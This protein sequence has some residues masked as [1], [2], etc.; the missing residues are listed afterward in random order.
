MVARYNK[1]VQGTCK[2][3]LYVLTSLRTLYIYS[4]DGGGVPNSSG[5]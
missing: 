4:H 1:I 2:P 5:R 3:Y